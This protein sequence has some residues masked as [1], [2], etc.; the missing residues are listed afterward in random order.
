[1]PGKRGGVASSQIE[2]TGQDAQAELPQSLRLLR[3]PVSAS[4]QQ[5]AKWIM[6]MPNLTNKAKTLSGKIMLCTVGGSYQPIVQA[7]EAAQP[8]YICFICT[9]R[10]RATGRPGSRSLVEDKGLIFKANREDDKATLPNIAQQ[11]SLADE[12]WEVLTVQADNFDDI[13]QEIMRWIAAQENP[14]IQWL[15]DYTGGTKTMSAALVAASLDHG[16]VHLQLVTGSR[17][18]LR[19]IDAASGF[20]MPAAVNNVRVQ[21]AIQ[22]ALESWQPYAYAEAYSLLQKIEPPQDEKLRARLQQASALSQAFMLWDRFDHH[23]ALNIIQPYR[24][25]FANKFP[26]LFSALD[27]LVADGDKREHLQLFD[28]WNNAQR[29]ATQQRYDD[30]IARGYRLIE[31]C[32]QWMLQTQA[33]IVTADVPEDKIPASLEL[34]RNRNGKFQA[35]LYAA[36]ELLASHCPGKA[37]DFWQVQR[38]TLLDL[39]QSRNQSILA[40]GYTTIDPLMWQKFSDW[41]EQHLLPLLLAYT[42]ESPFLIKQSPPQLPHCFPK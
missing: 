27:G 18:N 7:I 31:W 33:G 24:P 29:C 25:V 35:G 36:W 37:K 13:Y 15:A 5:T 38:N 32:A 6:T 21:R 17:G 4:F 9:D 34:S 12:R 20:I 16:K 40:H 10:D 19:Q 22:Q 3:L 26:M 11:L 1:M 39:L 28:L 8:D 14:D 23:K 2:E 41:V 30:A 42:R